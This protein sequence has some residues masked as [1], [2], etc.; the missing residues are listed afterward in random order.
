MNVHRD[1]RRDQNLIS[2]Y[3]KF[4]ITITIYITIKF[5]FF[6]FK[7]FYYIKIFDTIELS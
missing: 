3:D 7:G 6:F 5:F 4:D 2:R 1:G